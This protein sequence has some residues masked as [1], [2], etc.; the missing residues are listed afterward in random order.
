MNLHEI[1]PA[2]GEHDDLVKWIRRYYTHPDTSPND[3]KLEGTTFYW[4][5]PD[6]QWEMSGLTLEWW[7]RVYN[8]NQHR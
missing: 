5:Q 7:Y 6:G 8:E 2:Q 4:R 3:I 1:K